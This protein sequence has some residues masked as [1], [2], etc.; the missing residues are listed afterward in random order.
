VR[1]LTDRELA[2]RLGA[3]G[4]AL[5]AEWTYTVDEY[6]DR[7]VELVSRAVEARRG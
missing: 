5:S 7:V 6:A 4:R 1:L 2:K 3:G